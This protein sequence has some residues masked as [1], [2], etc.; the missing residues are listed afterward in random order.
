MEAR[1]TC[2]SRCLLF[3]SPFASSSVSVTPSP[4]SSVTGRHSQQPQ[5]YNFQSAGAESDIHESHSQGRQKTMFKRWVSTMV[6][7]TARCMAFLPSPLVLSSVWG[8][9][10]WSLLPL[11][12][13]DV[14]L[15]FQKCI[16]LLAP[17]SLINALQHSIIPRP[18]CTD[19]EQ[20]RSETQTALLTAAQ[21]CLCQLMGFPSW[22]AA[23]HRERYRGVILALK[24][25]ENKWWLE[26]WLHWLSVHRTRIWIGVPSP[27]FVETPNLEPQLWL[28][29]GTGVS[30]EQNQLEELSSRSSV[31]K[32]VSRGYQPTSGLYRQRHTWPRAPIPTHA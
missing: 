29:R 12:T 11:Y 8:R 16:P 13:S 31:S 20:T 15:C 5:S 9:H 10:R 28:G 4:R 14:L 23:A 32:V 1:P 22:T 17:E 25:K 3:F 30:L 7:P 24:T 26:R 21:K 18:L 27:A 2:C 6:K 19:R